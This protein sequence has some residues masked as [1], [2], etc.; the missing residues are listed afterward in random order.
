[1]WFKAFINKDL[2]R[3]NMSILLRKRK[4]GLINHGYCTCKIDASELDGDV[5]HGENIEDHTCPYSEDID[6][7]SEFKCNCCAYCIQ[8]CA[9]D[10]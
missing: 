8:E 7:D 1:M 3:N 5:S 9:N 6:G 10:I 2:K 4:G